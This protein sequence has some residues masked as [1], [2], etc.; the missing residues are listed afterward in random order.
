[1]GLLVRGGETRWASPASKEM[2]ERKAIEK[3]ITAIGDNDC[4]RIR[5]KNT[6]EVG[7][8]VSNS[9]ATCRVPRISLKALE[10]LATYLFSLKLII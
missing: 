4:H 7:G 10:R 2:K 3:V 8:R 9:S 1:M 5:R 6:G